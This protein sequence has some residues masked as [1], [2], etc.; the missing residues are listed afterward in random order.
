MHWIPV[1]RRRVGRP[2][3]TGLRTT[4]RVVRETDLNLEDCLYECRTKMHE[5]RLL[6]TYEPLEVRKGLSK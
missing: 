5:R 4:E 2:K 6:L 1:G 3:V